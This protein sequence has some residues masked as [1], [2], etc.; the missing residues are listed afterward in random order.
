M[1]TVRYRVDGVPDKWRDAWF[2][3]PTLTP[4][5]AT[6]VSWTIL[7]APGTMPVRSPRPQGS[8]TMSNSRE[9][10]PPS[11]VAP[12]YICPQLYTQDI[13]RLK[14]PVRY[15]PARVAEL[16]EPVVPIGQHGPQGPAPVVMGG[17]KVGCRR[18]MH[19][20][21]VITSWPGLRGNK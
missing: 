1:A 8:A 20:P 9:W 6:S 15:L 7:G 3:M 21:R 18:S 19:W 17:R 10:F 11:A 5:G 13:R 16:V 14:P 4:A 12:D 2:P